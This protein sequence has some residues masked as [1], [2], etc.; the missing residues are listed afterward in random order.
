MLGR[1]V[2]DDAEAQAC[3]S[4]I[5]IAGRVASLKRT[6]QAL[7]IC[8]G[9]AGALVRDQYNARWHRCVAQ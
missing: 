1:E 7:A 8:G 2:A 3:S 9:N 5:T 4:R 6:D